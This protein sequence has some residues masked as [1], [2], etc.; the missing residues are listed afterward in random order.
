MF[1]N[2]KNLSGYYDHQ[3]YLELV[4]L[5]RYNLL[6]LIFKPESVL[7]Q[8][9]INFDSI[10]NI[11]SNVGLLH[12]DTSKISEDEF[13][14][15]VQIRKYLN[16]IYSSSLIEFNE[17]ELVDL[18]YIEEIT[19]VLNINIESGL[20]ETTLEILKQ[21]VIQL[22]TLKKYFIDDKVFL[23]E[24]I[25]VAQHLE[26]EKFNKEKYFF[27]LAEQVCS[28]TDL[29]VDK[30]E[31]TNIITITGLDGGLSKSKIESEISKIELYISQKESF[32][33]VFNS[34]LIS[35]L[36]EN[37]S[38][39][40]ML[41]QYISK[42]DNKDIMA[43]SIF[44]KNTSNNWT[45]LKDTNIELS[46]EGHNR[47]SII[48]SDSNDIYSKYNNI[49]TILFDEYEIRKDV[50][51]LELIKQVDALTQI[52]ILK[53]ITIFDYFEECSVSIREVF[54][55]FGDWLEILYSILEG[56]LDE[57]INDYNNSGINV[58]KLDK[59]VFTRLLSFK[60]ELG[61]ILNW[62]QERYSE[63]NLYYSSTVLNYIYD[64]RNED[65]EDDNIDHLGIIL[66]VLNYSLKFNIISNQNEDI[67]NV[68]STPEDFNTLDIWNML[69]EV[70]NLAVVKY[71]NILNLWEQKTH[72]YSILIN[73]KLKTNMNQNSI[74]ELLL[75]KKIFDE[76]AKIGIKNIF[77]TSSSNF[78]ITKYELLVEYL[79]GISPY[80]VGSH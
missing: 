22:L 12:L 36:S 34:K 11:F 52:S 65:I 72:S 71:L 1:S 27:D 6:D 18:L 57:I 8:V 25:K 51:I 70:N 16:K 76:L 62:S 3:L 33:N 43:F 54:E 55:T 24:F 64:L 28:I 20:I 5:A 4:E 60:L 44:I 69:I 78:V 31:L 53:G 68:L 45:T 35:R 32:N 58:K 77:I 80:G 37:T 38:T 13:N 46:A 30:S 47:I 39:F 75:F 73:P 48:L 19:P 10:T 63:Y 50:L 74:N 17:T 14:F 7:H 79:K 29:F 67:I 56:N 61:R 23:K 15:K 42:L 21:E 49:K 66:A 9:G 41:L 2:L 40:K 59:Y 26:E